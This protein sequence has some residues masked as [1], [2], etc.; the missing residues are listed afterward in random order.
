MKVELRPHQGQAIT[1]VRESLRRLVNEG[2]RGR[3]RVVAC[4]G[5]GKTKILAELC[6]RV[7]ARGG[8]SL[9]LIHTKS[10]VD[11]TARRLGARGLRVGVERAAETVEQ[12]LDVDVVV[13]SVRSMAR[14]LDKYLQGSF[15]LLVCDE[16]DHTPSATQRKIIEHF[17]V[18]A[19]VCFS[20]TP[21]RCDGTLLSSIFEDVA[22][23]DDIAD[24][25]RDGY[26]VTPELVD[27]AIESLDLSSIK[28][29]GGEPA[30]VDLEAELLR[31][32]TMHAVCRTLA[33]EAE[34]RTAIQC[35]R[36]CRRTKHTVRAQ[37]VDT[38]E[39]D[40]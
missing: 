3:T 5:S 13:C 16:A 39:D 17:V 20:A 37:F 27:V 38:G 9:V 1:S 33:Q 28:F 8:R 24:G 7:A 36:G 31:D 40:V 21:D 19:A 6:N 30:A 32:A 26:L 22:F 4:T 15:A 29:R 2:R 10:L 34:D 14:R 12:L 25:V 18:A 35:G 23:V 11:Q